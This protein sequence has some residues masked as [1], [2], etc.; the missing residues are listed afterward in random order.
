MVVD[1]RCTGRRCAPVAHRRRVEVA[2]K[3]FQF[4]VE[5]NFLEGLAIL[6]A[7]QHP[8]LLGFG[9]Q[10]AEH[11]VRGIDVVLLLFGALG[12]SAVRLFFLR[13]PSS[14]CTARL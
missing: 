2:K 6:D 14:F 11:V 8:M 12:G 9:N 4:V 5:R 3:I 10:A 13:Q 7:Q 1:V